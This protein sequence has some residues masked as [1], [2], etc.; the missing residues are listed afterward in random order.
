MQKMNKK[1]PPNPLKKVFRGR[2]LK[3]KRTKIKYSCGFVGAGFVTMQNERFITINPILH[4]KLSMNDRNLPKNT[5][6]RK[7]AGFFDDKTL[8]KKSNRILLITFIV[9]IDKTCPYNALIN[10]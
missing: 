5:G 4:Y 1:Q 9:M 2:F 8:V 10:S 3:I 7:R 6:G